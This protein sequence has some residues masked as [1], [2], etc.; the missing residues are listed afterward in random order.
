MN[1]QHQSWMNVAA[2]AVIT[3]MALGLVSHAGT[4][5]IEPVTSDM[6]FSRGQFNMSFTIS[7]FTGIGVSLTLGWL[8]KRVK[9]IRVLLLLG[10]ISAFLGQMFLASAQNL[11]FVYLG[12]FFRGGAIFYLSSSPHAI[13]TGEW[14]KRKRATAYGVILAGSGVG[15]V[16]FSP[17]TNYWI[18]HYGWRM[19]YVISAVLVLSV[20]MIML[21][22]IRD[23]PRTEAINNG[24]NGRDTKSE[25]SQIHNDPKL[26][27]DDDSLNNG[28][29]LKEAAKTSVFWLAAI[30]VALIAMTIFAVYINT[31]AHLVHL[32]L[33]SQTVALVISAIFFI[34]TIAKLFLGVMADRLGVRP[35]FYFSIGC[36]LISVAL[37]MFSADP[38]IAFTAAFFFGFGFAT[39]SVPIPE[40]VR[41]LFGTKDFST[42][43]G[44]MMTCMGVGGAVGPLAG[45]MLFDYFDSYQPM[46]IAAIGFNALAVLLITLSMNRAA[47][48]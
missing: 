20:C 26:E 33:N 18:T 17:L 9:R 5:Y 12:G 16:V 38:V 6:G 28:L 46:M 43:L 1:N 10:I 34:N 2:S 42:M 14:F 29:T 24:E 40:L 4:L 41:Y 37:L 35:V 48:L 27:V 13:M 31:A 36:F 21:L 30:G 7:S 8:Y 23:K 44:I 47:K 19:A 15:G 22:L 39:V 3:M 45:G 25:P 32:Q 11:L